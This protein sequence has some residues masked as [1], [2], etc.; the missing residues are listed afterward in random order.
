LLGQ[1]ANGIVCEADWL[2]ERY[3]IKISK[4][5]YQEIFKREIAAL[6]GLHHPHIMHL[7]C[8]AEEKKKCSYVMELMDMTL[9]QGLENSKLSLVRG[10]D[11]MLQIAQGINYLHSM[12]LVHRDL[13]PDNILLQCD[14]PERD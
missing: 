6:S 13:K 7:V 2:G 8:C 1:G 10:V 12:D 14:H 9:S 5:A 4:Y 11:V 3:A